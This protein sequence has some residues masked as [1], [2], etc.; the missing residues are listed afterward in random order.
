[1]TTATYTCRVTVVE[2]GKPDA[3][4]KITPARHKEEKVWLDNQPGRERWEAIKRMMDNYGPKFGKIPEPV[5]THTDMRDLRSSDLVEENVPVVTLN[6][7]TFEAPPTEAQ[8][9]PLM[10]ETD[11][12]IENLETTLN[13]LTKL[14]TKLVTEKEPA[15]GID[16]LTGTT[17]TGRT[18]K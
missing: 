6:E 1:M 7:F 11:K 13:T 10:A 5:P 17:T 12:R 9:T 3:I 14:V 8:E 2:P 16:E 4:I 18:T 15:T